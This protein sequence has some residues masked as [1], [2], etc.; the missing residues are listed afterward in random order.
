MAL[1]EADPWIS[2]GD[3]KSE[4]IESDMFVRLVNAWHAEIGLEQKTTIKNIAETAEKL[5]MKGKPALWDVCLPASATLKNPNPKEIYN[6]GLSQAFEKFKDR[7]CDINNRQ[8]CITREPNAGK[9]TA[10][11]VLTADPDTWRKKKDGN[12]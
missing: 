5:N 11:W 12:S 10:S 3:V 4:D 1:D 8:V 6:L 7:T 2:A 9:G